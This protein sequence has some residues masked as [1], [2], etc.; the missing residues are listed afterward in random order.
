M[1]EDARGF[2]ALQGQITRLSQRLRIV[3]SRTTM[4][5]EEPAENKD[6]Q[7]ALAKRSHV[8]AKQDE[9]IKSL[10]NRLDEKDALIESQ[11][12]TIKSQAQELVQIHK[13]L[14]YKGDVHPQEHLNQVRRAAGVPVRPTRRF[15]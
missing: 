1:T 3:E 6:L 12:W 13:A 8:I 11:A 5:A 4:P 7:G 2:I 10:R 15:R 14:R 9:K